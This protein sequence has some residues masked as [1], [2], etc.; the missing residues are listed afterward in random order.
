VTAGDVLGTG[1]VAAN[2]NVS[3]GTL[4]IQ[5]NLTEGSGAASVTST[6]ALSG[7]GILNMDH[8]TIAVD[9][10]TMTG[11]TLKDVASFTAATTGG[12]DLQTASKLA[13]GIDTGFTTLG[14]TGTLTLGASSDLVL[15]LA[16]GFTPGSSFTL[17]GNDAAEAISGSFATINGS[18]FGV[19]NSFSLTND[20]GTFNYQLSYTGGTGNDL[21]MQVVPEPATWL[22][23]AGVGTFFMVVRRRNRL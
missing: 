15:I 10:F 12:L 6:V 3:S 11:G 21:L 1:S 20:M 19:G 9:T 14:L 2:V 18:A 23:L 22:L 4:L 13:F 17:V 7:T 8:G 16:S 5:G